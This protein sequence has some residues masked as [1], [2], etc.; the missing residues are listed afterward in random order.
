MKPPKS[1]NAINMPKFVTFVLSML[2]TC[3]WCL[4]PGVWASEIHWDHFQTPQINLSSQN[5]QFWST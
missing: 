2:E 5:G 3:F 1:H 4:S